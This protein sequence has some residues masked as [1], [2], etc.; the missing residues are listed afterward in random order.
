MKDEVHCYKRILRSVLKRIRDSNIPEQS[1]KNILD[2]YR[3]CILR[4]YSKART[5]KYLDTLERTARLLG[6]PFEE[7]KKLTTES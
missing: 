4:G 3:E 1:K 7:A 5:I 2:F 6:K